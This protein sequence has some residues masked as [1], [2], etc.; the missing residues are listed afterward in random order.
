LLRE[1]LKKARPLLARFISHLMWMH[2]E[3]ILND[4]ALR[5]LLGKDAI[6]LSK[7]KDKVVYITR[8]KD[9]WVLGLLARF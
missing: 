3:R 7:S 5:Y 4:L 9:A 2:L 8:I 1:F 6:I